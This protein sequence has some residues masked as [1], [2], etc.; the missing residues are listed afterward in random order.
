[1]QTGIS[2]MMKHATAAALAACVIGFAFTPAKADVQNRLGKLLA[3]PAMAGVC[4]L[5]VT[6][7]QNET[8][9]ALGPQLQKEA[10]ISDEQLGQI[11][12]EIAKGLK[13]EDCKDIK[14]HWAESV[15]AIIE[16]AKAKD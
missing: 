1:V 5:E 7:E 8:I 12:Q 3:L 11:T 10:G 6:A 9:N 13:P 2:I 14:A 15:P 4:G 16:Q